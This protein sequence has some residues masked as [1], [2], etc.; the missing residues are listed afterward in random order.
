V[1][2]WIYLG[3]F[4]FRNLNF[5]RMSKRNFAP[6]EVFESRYMLIRN[7]YKTEGG[8]ERIG[9]R[10][11][12]LLEDS[13]NQVDM[14][15]WENFKKLDKSKRDA[16]SRGSIIVLNSKDALLYFQKFRTKKVLVFTWNRSDFYFRLAQFCQK[17]NP[18]LLIQ[19]MSLDNCYQLTADIGDTKL[20]LLHSDCNHHPIRSTKAQAPRVVFIGRLN[21]QKG[22]DI[23]VQVAK[24]LDYLD[25]VI[26]GDGPLANYVEKETNRIKNLEYLGQIRKPVCELRGTDIVVIPSRYFEGLN[27]VL[28]ESLSHDLIVVSSGVGLMSTVISNNHLFPSKTL[29]K[30][31]LQ[32]WTKERILKSLESSI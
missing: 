28:L 32:N 16:M 14:I 23:F 17:R 29:S 18:S 27:L 19:E 30:R 31:E 13:G 12:K 15:S 2:I 9:V 5:L 6:E 1:L 26:V 20:E 11:Q 22:I 25:F 21:F 7:S 10:L 4:H 24:D 3:V 8:T